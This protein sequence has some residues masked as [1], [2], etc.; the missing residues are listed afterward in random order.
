MNGSLQ[1]PKQLSS[2]KPSA[3][4]LRK[5]LRMVC[6]T[7]MLGPRQP[8]IPDPLVDCTRADTASLGGFA[9]STRKENGF[10]DQVHFQ[11]LE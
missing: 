9:G 6:L 2:G 1:Q 5:T 3:R 7:R 11:R 8:T 4:R 10:F